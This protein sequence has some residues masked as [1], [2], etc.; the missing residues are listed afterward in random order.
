MSG[1]LRTR[2]LLLS[3]LLLCSPPLHAQTVASTLQF[4]FIGDTLANVTPDTYTLKVDTAAP[5]LI[6]SSCIQ[7]AVAVTCNWPIVPALTPGAHTLVVTRTSVVSGLSASGT[8]NYSPTAPI[9]PTTVR[10][11]ITVTVP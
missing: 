1:I 2:T 4:D 6:V 11:T 5:V 9:G 10:I 8:L 7:V 3:A